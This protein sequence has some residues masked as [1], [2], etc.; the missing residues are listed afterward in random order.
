M[1]LSILRVLIH[2]DPN[3]DGFIDATFDL[4]VDRQTNLV[5]GRDWRFG[6]ARF[7]GA[8]ICPFVLRREKRSRGYEIDFGSGFSGV[9]Q[10]WETDIFDVPIVIGQA[11]TFWNKSL[12]ERYGRIRELHVIM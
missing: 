8:P 4:L 1:V 6:M 5:N 3:D 9:D 12:L 2:V 11:V 10:Y 7:N